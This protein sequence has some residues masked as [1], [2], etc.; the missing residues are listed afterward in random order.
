MN[1]HKIK[2]WLALLLALMLN[3]VWASGSEWVICIR[4]DGLTRVELLSTHGCGTAEHAAEHG[5]GACLESDCDDV[6]I[7]QATPAIGKISFGKRL[8]V[9]SSSQFSAAGPPA[10]GNLVQASAGSPG[11]PHSLLHLRTVILRL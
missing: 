1:F 4:G 2:T 7:G 5:D 11:V 6:P 9:S 10:C 3:V 8:T